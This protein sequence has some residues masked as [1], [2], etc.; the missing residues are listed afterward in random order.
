VADRTAD[1][2]LRRRLFY[3]ADRRWELQAREMLAEQRNYADAAIFCGS[4]N[5]LPTNGVPA[6][7]MLARD[8][9]IPDWN[10]GQ[11]RAPPETGVRHPGSSTR[12]TTGSSWSAKYCDSLR[13]D[14]LNPMSV[15]RGGVEAFLDAIT[16][17]KCIE[18]TGA[19]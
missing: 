16:E 6:K 7:R 1:P 5:R 10:V 18:L 11:A 17:C 14:A 19:Q 8:L 4:N 12:R 15:T 9:A 3:L 2:A 13:N